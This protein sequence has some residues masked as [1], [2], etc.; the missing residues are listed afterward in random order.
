MNDVRTPARPVLQPATASS[1]ATSRAT[2]ELAVLD[3]VDLDIVPGEIVGLI[4]TI[5]FGQIVAA[6]TPPA[7]LSAPTAAMFASMAISGWALSEDERTAIRR[8]RIGFVYQFHHLLPE[9]DAHP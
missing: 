6:C 1:G 7:C 4:G 5:G 3:G 2:V 9:F 8:N